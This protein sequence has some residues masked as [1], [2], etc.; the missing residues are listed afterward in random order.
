MGKGRGGRGRA[1]S[2]PLGNQA[3]IQKQQNLAR[4]HASR[5]LSRLQRLLDQASF[6]HRE[7]WGKEIRCADL[8]T[9]DDMRMALNQERRWV[10][11][12][13]AFC[14]GSNNKPYSPTY[15]L[16]TGVCHIDDLQEHYLL[17]RDRLEA[18]QNVNHLISMGWVAKPWTPELDK[19]LEKEHGRVERPS[20]AS[21]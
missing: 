21:A 16:V 4:F 6:E 8:D 20:A 15:P 2:L 7:I 13:T 18:E 11:F 10:L 17:H 14:L 3:G 12:V 9:A 5:G 19:Q 1:G